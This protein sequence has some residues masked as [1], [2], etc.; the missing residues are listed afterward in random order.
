M[1]KKLSIAQMGFSVSIEYFFHHCA[2]FWLKVATQLISHL[3]INHRIILSWGAG[4][5]MQ[6]PTLS[7]RREYLGCQA[8][9]FA[10]QGRYLQI[11][12][13]VF[14]KIISLGKLK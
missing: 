13:I 10:G 2:I 6:S 12:T 11:M 4:S 7:L 5:S 8:W 1:K 3:A 14:E 9:S